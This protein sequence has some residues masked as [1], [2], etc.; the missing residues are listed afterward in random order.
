MACSR[1]AFI[2]EKASRTTG[3]WRRLN[4]SLPGTAV[5]VFAPQAAQTTHMFKETTIPLHHT[6][7]VCDLCPAMPGIQF[8]KSK[9]RFNA[10]KL[11]WDAGEERGSPMNPNLGGWA[12][13]ARILTSS[14]V[15]A[16]TE[17]LRTTAWTLLELEAT[18]DTLQ[19][20]AVCLGGHF[21]LG[22]RLGIPWGSS[23]E[24]GNLSNVLI[25]FLAHEALTRFWFHLSPRIGLRGRWG[26]SAPITPHSSEES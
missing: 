7:S 22:S 14:S 20:Q 15:D 25:E 16:D 8:S 10:I 21:L 2:Y 17:E 4:L 13:L 11:W 24:I 5:C 23:T 3:V 18:R 9:H 6:A 19:V 1:P 26:G 12:L